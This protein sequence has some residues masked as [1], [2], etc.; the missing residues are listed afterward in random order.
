LEQAYGVRLAEAEETIETVPASPRVASLLS[1]DPG[2]P[3][4]LLSR[5]SFGDDGTPVEFV[6]SLYRGDRYRFVTRLRRPR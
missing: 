2:H 5:H 3:L 4:L 1:T 6:R